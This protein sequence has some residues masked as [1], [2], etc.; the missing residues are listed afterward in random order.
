MK[1]LPLLATLMVTSALAKDAYQADA[2]GFQKIALPFLEKHCITC[3]NDEKSKGELNIESDLPN[4]FL[5]HSTGERWGEILNVINGHEMPPKKEP[6]P[7]PQEA[8]RFADWVAQE[9][10]RAELS[11]KNNQI[12]L[13]R[14][15][16]AEYAN[17]IRD[18]LNIEFNPESFPEDPPASGFD[19]IGSALTLSPLHLELYYN[20]AREI[21]DQAI[22]TGDQ[23]PAIKWR[24]D[25]E[26]S[27]QGADRTRVERGGQ[28]I[29]L[30]GGSKNE[31]ED[32]FVVAR[33]TSW[34]RIIGF[35][36][37]KLPF[38]GQYIIRIRA[39]S[40]VP[41]RNDVLEMMTPILSEREHQ[42]AQKR[43]REVNTK[44]LEEQINHFRVDRM[45]D[46]GPARIRI[47]GKLSGQPFFSEEFD[48][49]S[50][51]PK[52]KDFEFRAFFTTEDGGIQFKP[53]YEIPRVLENFW[54][55]GNDDF[56]R[57]EAMVDWIE[58][59][60]P[61]Y[62]TWPPKSQTQLFSG[63]EKE[64]DQCG[65][66]EARLIIKNFIKKAWRRPITQVELDRKMELFEQQYHSTSNFLTSLKP[67]LISILISPNFLFLTEQT[68]Q[69]ELLTDDELATR[70][71]YFLW[72]S[73]PDRELE[74]LAA[75]QKLREPSVLKEQVDRLLASEK[76]QALTQ[77][78]A[79]QWLELR[80][81]GTNPPASDLFPRYDRHL[82]TSLKGESLAFF[83]EILHQDLDVMNFVKSNFVTINERLGRYYNIPNIRGDHF[84]K[85]MVPEGVS[86]GGIVTQAS[87][88][89]ITSNGTR[90]S[91]VVRGTW[92]LKNL[93]G[94]DPGLPVANVGEI[95][96]KV[97]GIDK[98][99]VRQ[100]LAIHREL[101]QCA[102]CHDKIDPLGLSLENFNAA[103][104][105]RE[106]EGFG[107]KGRIGQND[108]L[109]NASAT[110]PDGTEFVGVSGLQNQLLEKE[111]LFLRCLSKKLFT[112]ALGRELG[113]ADDPIIDQAIASMRKNGKTLR[114][115]IHFIVTSKP[116]RSK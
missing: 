61:I 21:I 80:K 8:G 20:A 65:A 81:I 114:S 111:D 93:L 76:S 49:D 85:V 109:I 90:T 91:P 27:T 100:R 104:E 48:I 99:T 22:V 13:R 64:V 86:R 98:A 33:S 83:R 40:R 5:D 116:F 57:P 54:I 46:Y 52:A 7:D 105:W 113:Y 59:E 106:R 56:P 62:E 82:E 71:S 79:S 12:V 58:I 11:T 60:G 31:I 47:E 18:L 2:E 102:R 37:F 74:K 10:A 73:M 36:G 89:S 92:I 68:P 67:V 112:Y 42:E 87:I 103:G 24:F 23:P 110:M 32:G 88:L 50:T 72:S 29:L 14:L 94:T 44:H 107:Y 97:P 19:N 66:Q 26:E 55:Q 30:N 75:S 77:N 41:S 25:P 3:H 95:A 84:Q 96:P 78:F 115:L 6:Q 51:W 45:Y 28:R 38:A 43:N 15:N 108:P 35:R 63:I 9:L 34:D 69:G 1:P 101:A 53:A 39:S 16:R 4:S 17:T 70:L